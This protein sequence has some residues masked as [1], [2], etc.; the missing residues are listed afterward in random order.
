[1]NNYVI[2]SEPPARGYFGVN[3]FPLSV[4]DLPRLTRAETSPGERSIIDRLMTLKN[5]CLLSEE[6]HAR[7]LE[8]KA[9]DGGC[10]YTEIV[11]VEFSRLEETITDQRPSRFLGYDISYSDG[12]FFSAIRQG[13]FESPILPSLVAYREKLNEFGLLSDPHD[14]PSFLTSYLGLAQSERRDAFALCQISGVDQT[15]P[16]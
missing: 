13:V 3:R 6:A 12:D 7:F 14:A 4:F 5:P 10:I 1:M 8:R 9:R 2:L 11:Q 16:N 15:Y